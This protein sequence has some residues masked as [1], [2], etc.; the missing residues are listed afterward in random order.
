MLLVI[1]IRKE[2]IVVFFSYVFW[3]I[4]K[5]VGFCVICLE[6]MS[7]ELECMDVFYD[8]CLIDWLD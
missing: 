4:E 6:E 7:E 5:L 1:F 8:D 3:M 2:Y